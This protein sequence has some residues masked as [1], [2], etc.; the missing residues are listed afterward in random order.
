MEELRIVAGN[1]YSLRTHVTSVSSQP[2][3]KVHH[4]RLKRRRADINYFERILLFFPDSTRCIMEDYDALRRELSECIIAHTY[5]SEPSD[6]LKECEDVIPRVQHLL[7]LNGRLD[8][9]GN[10]DG[11][12][13]RTMLSAYRQRYEHARSCYNPNEW[14]DTWVECADILNNLMRIGVRENLIVL[15]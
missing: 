2:R 14:K 12:T 5:I 7:E 11:W 8:A 10:S 4:V 6:I 3:G 9:V 13:Y 1:A 15:P